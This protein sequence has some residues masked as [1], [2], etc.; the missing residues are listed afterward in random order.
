MIKTVGKLK[1]KVTQNVP[2][3]VGT[4]L[5]CL[6]YRTRTI[7][8]SNTKKLTDYYFIVSEKYN[9]TTT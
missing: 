9:G 7:F 2:E 5:I 4:S 1:R 6:K 8:I 3:Q